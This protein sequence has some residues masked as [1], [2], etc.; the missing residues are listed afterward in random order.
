VAYQNGH[1]GVIPYVHFAQAI[2]MKRISASFLPPVALDFTGKVPIYRQLYEWFRRAIGAGQLKPGQ[3][4]PSTRSLAAELKVSRIPVSNAYEQLRAEGY[5][6]TFVG[7]GTCV[8]R[9]I[10]ADALRPAF[11]KMRDASRRVSK[12]K[13]PRLVSRRVALMRLPAQTWSNKLVA[14]RVNLPALEHFPIGEWSKLVNRY[15]RKPTR[16]S[17]AYGD[18]MGYLPLREAIAEYLGAARAVR[19]KPSQVLVTTGS[20]QCLQ[21]S[22]QVLL[23][24][25]DPVWIEEPGYPGARQALIMAGAQLVPVPVDQEGLNVAEG[26]K[27]GG[28]AR[29]VYITPSHQYPL[30][31]TMTATRRMLL[32]NWA[33]RSGAWIIE[34]DYDSEYRLEGRPIPSLQGLD[35]SQQVIYVGTFSKVMFPALRLGYMV[36][37]EDLVDAFSAARE[38]ADQFSSTLYQAV[39]TDFIREGHFARHIR[40]MR[41]LYLER[42]TTLVE[43]IHGQM[44]GKLEVIGTEAGMH[45]VAL[46]PAGVN[47]VALS[48]KAAEAGISA[49][50][51]SACC[52]KPPIRSGLILGY[53]GTDT[54]QIRDGIRKLRLLI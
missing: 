38:A 31:V 53:G 14:F 47:D 23:D 9:S 45:L 27:R 33:A 5:L 29:A 34:D 13:A 51:L 42:R 8:V 19:C 25:N 17:L 32:L 22:A 7:A 43:G 50:P 18:A 36:V 30:G 4:V 28:S 2:A 16:Q 49:M 35:E 10:P 54:R 37:P 40:R 6:E 24:V 3:R 44:G 52:L 41:M 46:L 20:Q 11:G 12:S 39:M 26:I 15:S 21:L 1:F 48:K